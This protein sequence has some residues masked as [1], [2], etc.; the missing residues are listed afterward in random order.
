MDKLFFFNELTPSGSIQPEG[1]HLAFSEIA[2]KFLNAKDEDGLRYYLRW[3]Q[4]AQ[5]LD[6]MLD[7]F[8]RRSGLRIDTTAN[9][10]QLLTAL[11]LFLDG[12]SYDEILE[13][14]PEELF[15]QYKR[16]LDEIQIDRKKAWQ[17][18]GISAIVFNPGDGNHW[19]K[20]M[21]RG[22]WP[23]NRLPDPLEGGYGSGSDIDIDAKIAED[24]KAAKEMEDS[25]EEDRYYRENPDAI[26]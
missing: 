15:D 8:L 23:G 17:G 25:I 11:I 3:H 19:T 1:K 16:E 5:P 21:E 18:P 2:R 14:D 20:G 9:F 26:N 24:E 4:D 10:H 12:A 22:S 7:L 6:D 13:A